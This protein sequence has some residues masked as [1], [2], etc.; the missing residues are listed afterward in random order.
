ML[1]VLYI[2]LFPSRLSLSCLALFQKIVFLYGCRLMSTCTSV[3]LLCI[4]QRDLVL[5]LTMKVG[6]ERVRRLIKEPIVF[7]VMWFEPLNVINIYIN[8]MSLI[9]IY[10]YISLLK[11]VFTKSRLY[12]LDTN[13]KQI[14][15]AHSMLT[16]Q[17]AI[18]CDW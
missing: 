6:Q 11:R 15:K 10:I 7:H 4:P 2:S 13:K 12:Y 14:P 9:Y 1:R 5:P 18:H 16:H 17:M 8:T 3:L